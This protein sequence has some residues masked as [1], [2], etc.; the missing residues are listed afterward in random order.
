[1]TRRFDETTRTIDAQVKY[2]EDR[3]M[4][5]V[6]MI[7]ES[8]VELFQVRESIAALRAHMTA[9]EMEP[10]IDYQSIFVK[11]SMC[12]DIL[13]VYDG[14]WWLKSNP[15]YLF[16]RLHG[17]LI[18]PE[19]RICWSSDSQS[20]SPIAITITFPTDIFV[21]VRQYT[22]RSWLG[23]GSQ[24]SPYLKGWALYGDSRGEWQLLSKVKCCTGF[25]DSK[26]L[27]TTIWTEIACTAFRLCSLGRNRTG[28]SQMH[29]SQFT[30]M[31]D[32]ISTPERLR[33]RPSVHWNVDSTHPEVGRAIHQ[34]L[35][36][37]DQ[38]S[39]DEW[40]SSVRAEPHI[41]IPNEPQ[42]EAP[43]VVH[44]PETLNEL[45]HDEATILPPEEPVDVVASTPV[46]QSQPPP[47]SAAGLSLRPD[48][49][50]GAEEATANLDVVVANPNVVVIDENFFFPLEESQ[51]KLSK[52]P[53]S[54]S[55][56]HHL[57]LSRFGTTRLMSYTNPN[58]ESEFLV[59]KYY[60]IGENRSGDFN[61]FIK[62]MITIDHPHVMSIYAVNPPTNTTGP[63]LFTSYSV[64]GSLEDVLSRARR[65]D[66]PP[67]WNSAGKLRTI[68]S[69]ISGLNRLHAQR[70]VH[71]DLK[72]ADLI[73]MNDGS[74]RVYGFV[75]SYLEEARYT[76]ASQVG[77]PSYM[78]PEIFDN[79][80]GGAMLRD[81]KT[82]IFSFGL[83][84]YEIISDGRK[85]FLS[86]MSAATIMR[87]AMSTHASDRPVIPD[88]LHPIFRELMSRTWVPVPVKRA[89]PE[90]LWKRIRGVRFKL[91]PD[92]EVS[93][94]RE[95]FRAWK[96]KE[97]LTHCPHARN[98]NA[99]IPALPTRDDDPDVFCGEEPEEE[100]G[101]VDLLKPFPERRRTGDGRAQHIILGS[102]WPC[103]ESTPMD[104]GMC[105]I[106]AQSPKVVLVQ[107]RTHRP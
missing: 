107:F 82:D 10:P 73:V 31:G 96:C 49:P 59:A 86:T 79:E 95:K 7:E 87:R 104:E 94:F 5:N 9:Y 46:L 56:I 65:H 68:V 71:R 2:A 33:G 97:Y 106:N 54:F 48:P 90:T 12:M 39:S 77:G 66:S 105:A 58:G 100:V 60:N 16:D 43:L 19:T 72:P 14:V 8:N 27:T 75:T 34:P 70:F 23:T 24:I 80:H 47:V 78:A 45:A 29:L 21:V 15:L 17:I 20:R 13:A 57:G 28:Y 25:A 61:G 89:S 103:G 37:T 53:E 62:Q 35:T 99:R 40:P 85:I 92:V 64:N 76:K 42:P 18:S 4:E 81:P 11:Y 91:F 44:I 26:Q 88:A 74:V 50:A 69:M 63:I 3:V 6:S 93:F 22:L 1:M 98:T 102:K 38:A 55:E 83:I 30:L 67:F 101:V 32:V 36:T 52:A 41:D 51:L 84:V